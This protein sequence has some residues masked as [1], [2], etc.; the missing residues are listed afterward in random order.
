MD[1]RYDQ[2]GEDAIYAKWEKSGYFNPDNLERK[3]KPFTII[4]PPP[5]AN[6]SLHIGHALFVTLQDIMIRYY[7]M[8]GRKALWLPGADHAGFETQVVYNK[9]LEKEGRSFWEIPKDKLYEEIKEFTL[10]NKQYMESQLR[11]LGASCDWSREK[12]TLDD[13]IREVVYSTFKKLYDDGLI[14]RAERPVNWCAK[15]QTTLSDLEIKYEEKVDKLYYV[16]YSLSNGNGFIEVATTRPETIAADIAIAVHPKSKWAEFVGAKALN[17]LTKKEMPVITDDAVD[18]DFGTGALKITP[19]H[20]STDFEIW[21]RHKKEI[22][23]EPISVIDRYGKMDPSAG[24]LSGLKV[25]DAREKAAEILKD[26]F[27]REPEDYNHQVSVCYKCGTVIEPRV[28]KQWFVKMTDKPNKGGSSLRDLAVRAVR[29]KKVRFVSSRFE[30]EFMRWMADLRDWNISRQIVW[31]IKIPVWYC[32]GQDND[33]CR[34]KEGIIVSESKLQKCPY[35]GSENIRAENDVF[36][37]WFSSGQWPFATLMS[38]SGDFK[39]FYPTDV[40]E[41]GWDILF[42]W[43]ARM[44]MFGIYRTGK[45]PFKTVYLH[46]LVRDKDRQKMSKS[47]GNV[48]NPLEVAEVYG[49]DAVRMSLVIGSAAGNDP[50]IS[51]DKIRGYRNFTTKIWNAARFV[52]MD[53]AEP[54][55]KPSFTARDKADLKE[56]EKTKKDVAKHIEKLDFNHAAEIAYHYFWHSFADKVIEESK[57][58]IKSDDLKDPSRRKFAEADAE[59]AKEKLIII[60]SECLK[61]LHPFMP[62]VTES[63]WQNMPNKTKKGNM[64]MIEPW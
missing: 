43:V 19:Y 58:R 44:I 48:V 23:L 41:T 22:E 61:M 33:V 11:K 12:F 7:R 15:H 1:I 45:V 32:D 8:N 5:N 34:S 49:T 30:K 36:D 28:M 24:A 50:V 60:L 46:G 25:K 64:L 51:E 14:Y 52:L 59:A 13:D 3:G 2:S 29:S 55:R 27:S 42:F 62:F 18:P 35:C 53:Y 56:M 20:D 10:A 21:S 31:G 38:K 37:T 57:E 16:K 9:K 54:S 39:K 6:G 17:P 40:M 4:M 26:S 47:K 63:I